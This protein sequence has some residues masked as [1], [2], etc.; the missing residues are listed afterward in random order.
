MAQWSALSA[1]TRKRARARGSGIQFDV[2]LAQIYWIERG[3]IVRQSDFGDWDEAL[4]VVGVQEATEG[5]NRG[6]SA[7]SSP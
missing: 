6:R 3:L 5:S 4:R 2:S 7:T 1:F